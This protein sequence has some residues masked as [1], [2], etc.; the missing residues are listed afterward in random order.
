VVQSW[1]T[2]AFDAEVIEWPFPRPRFPLP[3]PARRPTRASFIVFAHAYAR[4]SV[5]VLFFLA[6]QY[7]S[8]GTLT[9]AALQLPTRPCDHARRKTMDEPVPARRQ[10]DGC[11]GAVWGTERG[12]R[13]QGHLGGLLPSGDHGYLLLTRAQ[14][15]THSL[16]PVS[17]NPYANK[18]HVHS[19]LNM[20]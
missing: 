15:R 14:L 10:L 1:W 3:T 4:S 5:S 2:P 8:L 18:S 20:P 11:L 12:S 6:R 16:E 17:R 19:H 9:T 7:Y 13:Y